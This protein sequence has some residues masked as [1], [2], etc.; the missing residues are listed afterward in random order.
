M[1]IVVRQKNVVRQGY[2]KSIRKK[3]KKKTK[4][5][6]MNTVYRYL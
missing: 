1:I 4:K 2:L 5:N 3:N 6:K